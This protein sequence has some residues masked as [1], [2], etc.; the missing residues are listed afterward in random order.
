M[1]TQHQ[2]MPKLGYGGHSSYFVVHP[3]DLLGS[4]RRHDP[5]W[6]GC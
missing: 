5:H 1:V 4:Q 3:L 6:V 2:M